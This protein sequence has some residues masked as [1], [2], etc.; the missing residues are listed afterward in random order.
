VLEL[1]GSATG[2]TPVI[3]KIERR[4][5]EVDVTAGPTVRLYASQFDVPSIGGFLI[6][7]LACRAQPVHL[8][9]AGEHCARA[10]VCASVNTALCSAHLRR[11]AS[12]KNA[13][14]P[15]TMSSHEEGSGIGAVVLLSA[16]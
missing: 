7:S 13:P 5:S 8:D 6:D 9:R 1:P 10:E 11:A 15:V 4:V 12:A 16:L 14:H 3:S 2:K